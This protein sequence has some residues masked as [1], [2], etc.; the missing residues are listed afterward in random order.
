MGS[1]DTVRALAI[2][3]IVLGASL[4]LA[5]RRVASGWVGSDADTGAASVGRALGARDVV[6]GGM[7]L[8]ILDN[9]QV[10]QRWTATCGAV[11]AVDGLAL[12]AARR[13]IPTVRGLAWASALGSAVGH[14]ALS[15][16]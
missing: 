10:A 2:G 4:V 6:L 3:R 1:R 14:F 9:P 12:L 7:L 16:S 13:E 15:R 5:P 8:H 11:D